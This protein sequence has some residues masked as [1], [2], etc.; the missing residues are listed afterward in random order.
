[1]RKIEAI[2]GL[3]AA[4]AFSVAA[5]HVLH[6]AIGLDPGGFASRL[7]DALPWQ[8]G[9]D[10]FFVISG[11]VMVYSSGDLFGHRSGRTVFMTRRLVRIVPLYWAA[12]TLF[13]LIAMIAPSAISHDDLTPARVAMSYAFIPALSSSGLIQPI[14]SLGWTLNYEM[15]FYVVF[16]AFISQ[17]RTRA[18]LLIGVTLGC[19]IAAHPLVPRAA[20]AFVFWTDP[21][22]AEFLLGVMIGVL[23]E[24][25][26]SLPDWLRVAGALLAV[27]ALVAGHLEGVALSEPLSVGVPMAILVAMAVFGRPLPIPALLV[28]IGEASYALYLV[29]PF[30]M[31]GVSLVWR[32]LHLTGPTAA[33]CY[34]VVSLVLA[35]LSAVA[36][37]LWFERPVSAWLRTRTARF[38]LVRSS[39]P[40]A[41]A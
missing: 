1:V 31:R 35:V 36:T 20:T 24:T 17:T 23:A 30:A 5:L 32:A 14:Y 3:R 11:F 10:L 7:H 33:A 27:T 39:P 29:H 18:V 16:A 6:D 22:M 4:A 12:T 9:V 21:I 15:F 19:L 28:L 40:R 25:A 41:A 37:H 34:I 26:L 38:W 13:L 2:Q 8:A